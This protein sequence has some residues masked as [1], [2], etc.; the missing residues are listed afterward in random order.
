MIQLAASYAPE[1]L[2][3]IAEF[4]GKASDIIEEQ[5]YSLSSAPKTKS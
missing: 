5:I 3:L 2:E 4:L 1:E